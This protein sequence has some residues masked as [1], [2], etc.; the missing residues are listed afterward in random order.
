[1]ATLRASKNRCALALMATVP[2]PGI[3][4]RSRLSPP[5]SP[6]D[7]AG[8]K[9]CFLRDAVTSM[10]EIA[11]A[12]RAEGVILYSPSGAETAA[13]EIAPKSFKAFPQRGANLGQVL[14]NVTADLLAR[15]FSSVCLL[16]F[17]SPTLP[18]SHIEVALETV[19]RPG[20]RL[21]LTAAEGGGYCLIACKDSYPE[22]FE[23]ITTSGANFLTHTTARAAQIGLK[24]EMLP[25]WY[26]VDD[27][28]TLKRLREE[29]N[30]PDLRLS[31]TSRPGKP[32]SAHYTR[33]YVA[34]L[35][36]G[37]GAE[38]IG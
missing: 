19:N 24:I 12:G 18:R 17:E 5:L 10:A 29:L 38:Q 28:A 33:Q 35:S 1:M 30:D 7:V 31:S 4:V 34:K 8:L 26:N 21:V 2:L 32:H 22:I 25:H 16:N 20:D 9:S 3:E 6:A 37:E 36:E 23:R 15:G 14:V 27:P 11:G 13:R